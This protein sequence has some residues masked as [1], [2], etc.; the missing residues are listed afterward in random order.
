MKNIGIFE[1]CEKLAKNFGEAVKNKN[2][3][4]ET[5]DIAV[6]VANN[7]FLDKVKDNLFRKCTPRERKFL[8][9]KTTEG[10]ALLSS[11]FKSLIVRE[12]IA[13][14]GSYEFEFQHIRVGITDSE[15]NH[16]GFF[17]DSGRDEIREIIDGFSEELGLL[18]QAIFYSDEKQILTLYF[19]E[20]SK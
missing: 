1:G 4:I 19:E 11:I 2:V 20:I 17:F 10:I 14:P 7:L 5:L 13:V 9:L 18:F 6:G 15:I 8:N 16:N 12:S 3:V